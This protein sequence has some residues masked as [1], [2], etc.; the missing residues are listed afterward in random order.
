MISGKFNLFIVDEDAEALRG[1]NRYL[2]NRFGKSLIISSFTTAELAVNHIDQ[3]TSLVVLRLEMTV[4]CMKQVELIKISYPD[5]KVLI[6]SQRNDI[7]LAVESI[8]NHTRELLKKSNRIHN[9]FIRKIHQALDF[10]LF[11]FFG[12]LKSTG[13]RKRVVL[14]FGIIR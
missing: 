5:T 1:L 4:S 7:G 12:K 8:Q 11:S 14:G 9:R 2:D 6:Q 3:Q 10:V 13:I